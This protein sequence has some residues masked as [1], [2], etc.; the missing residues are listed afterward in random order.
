M[1]TRPNLQYPIDAQ[2]IDCGREEFA[3]TYDRQ[4]TLVDL[5]KVGSVVDSLL[6]VEH[7]DVITVGRSQN[8][9]KNILVGNTIPLVEI[10]RGGNVTYHG[11]GQIVGYPIVQLLEGERDLH[12]F[13]R[14][15]EQGIIDALLE[16]SI[17]AIRSQGNTGV[18]VADKK[19]ASIGISCRRWVTFHGFAINISTDLSKFAGIRPCGFSAEIM[20]S[21]ERELGAPVDMQAFKQT[22]TRCLGN[23]LGRRFMV[24]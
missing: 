13:L 24:F 18:W 3:V 8:A 14:N 20:T 17:P 16:I 1:T 12:R 5:R 4:K 6:L 21:A 22:L 11:P 2:Y 23:A 19:I 7:P 9:K 15:I 10:E